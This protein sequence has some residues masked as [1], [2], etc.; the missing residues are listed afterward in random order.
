[1]VDSVVSVVIGVLE[2]DLNAVSYILF[3]T[4][5]AGET[6]NGRIPAGFKKLNFAPHLSSKALIPISAATSPIVIGTQRFQ[7]PVPFLGSIQGRRCSQLLSQNPVS[8]VA[9]PELTLP[10]LAAILFCS[11]SYFLTKSGSF[12]ERP[13]NPFGFLSFISVI[14]YLK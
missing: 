10:E 1:M 6:I 4:R 3:I 7:N 5:F 2:D 11:A 8:D 12:L 13:K 14:A 9:L